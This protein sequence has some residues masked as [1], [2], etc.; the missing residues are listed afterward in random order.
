MRNYSLAHLSDERLLHDLGALMERERSATVDVLVHIAEVDARKLYAPAGYS[1]MHAYCVRK[2][3]LSEDAAFKRIR[4]ARAG[5]RLPVLFTALA[6]G[7]IH[8]A[9][10][11]LLAPHL[12]PEN[13][14][15]ILEA[16]THR[17]KSEIEELVAVRFQAPEGTPSARQAASIRPCREVV[18][19]QAASGARDGELDFGA[20]GPAEARGTH[21]SGTPE[22]GTPEGGE[23]RAAASREDQLAPGPVAEATP[24]TTPCVESFLLRVTIGKRFHDK[25]RRAQVLLSHSVPSGDVARVLERALDD[26]IAGLE[27]RR[28]GSDSRRKTSRPRA[29]RSR[30]I[31]V[32]IRRAVWERDRAQCTFVGTDGHRCGSKEL[33]QIDHVEPYA[34]RPEATAEKLRLLCRTHNQLEAD[35]VFGTEFM[36]R[37]REAI[38]SS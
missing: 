17:A 3:R 20:A 34:R 11:Y 19:P 12:T 37:K 14:D 10:A 38:S 18:T 8:L 33:L 9:A 25:L 16:A 36:R 21:E 23:P 6:E 31:P 24:V 13:V 15:E 4:A 35:R 27:R 22:S 28:V 5:R 29:A 1:S 7:R 26:L 30:Y 32:E 2:L